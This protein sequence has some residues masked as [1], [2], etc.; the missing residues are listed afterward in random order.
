M[1]QQYTFILLFMILHLKKWK[2]EIL[3]ILTPKTLH[4][5]LVGENKWA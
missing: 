1:S 2:W 5:G 4:A 3:L